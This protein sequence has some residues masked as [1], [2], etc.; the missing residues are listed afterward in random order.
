MECHRE[1]RPILSNSIAEGGSMKRSTQWDIVG[2]FGLVLGLGIMISLFYEYMPLRFRDTP[3]DYIMWSIVSGI[4]ILFGI[5]TFI[6]G[7]LEAKKEE[8]RT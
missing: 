7:Y 8:A 3:S 4:S 5:V 6:F 1:Q 2:V